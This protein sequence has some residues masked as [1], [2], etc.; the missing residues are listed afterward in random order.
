VRRDG[1]SAARAEPDLE[2]GVVCGGDRAD[3]RQAEPVAVRM[4]GA[5]GGEP[6]ERPEELAD[7]VGGHRR[8]GVGDGQ[9]GVVIAGFGA[10]LHAAARQ[11][12][13]DRVVDQVGGHP[14]GQVR[15]AV[16]GGV[17]EPDR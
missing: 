12:V 4:A 11:V 3:D 5:V 10:H 2:A 17:A 7:L 8:T 9:D 15:V 14:L 6:L 13:A 16:H 1:E